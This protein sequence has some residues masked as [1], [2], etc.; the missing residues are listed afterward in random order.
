MFRDEAELDEFLSRPSEADIRAAARLSGDVIILGAGGKMGPTLALRLRR[1]IEA[2]NSGVRVIAAARFNRPEIYELLRGAGVEVIRTDLLKPG[3][4]SQLPDAPN[5][6]FMAATKFGTTGA[7]ALT[8]ATNAFL[9][10]LVAER[11]RSSQIVAFSTGNVYPLVSP[12][13]GGATEYTPVAPIG[14]YAQSA[15]GRERVFEHGSRTYGTRV[16][17]IRLNY[18][19][20]LRYGVL[21]DIGRK[22]FSR[23]PVDV[24]MG[25]VNVIWQG[26]A[27][28]IGLRALL[29]CA[30]P[31]AVFNV[32]GP[33]TL[34]VRWIANE[35][36]R[37]FGL[38]PL[39]EGDEGPTALISNSAR[40]IQRFGYPSVP[41][42]QMIEWA[43]QWI[44]AGGSTFGKPTRFEVRDGRF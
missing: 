9:P 40:A 33:E 34:S 38:E 4:I 36:G 23:E 37:R 3:A 35:F 14:E 32:T 29:E 8:W 26:D 42:A 11:Y 15:V 30:S 18:A 22:V 7:E 5:V 39:I 19:T 41:P 1:A 25:L 31:P 13:S 44:S 20:E 43:A 28:S 24:N 17:I 16:A 2:S 10:G 12:Q 21:V 6:I 27:N